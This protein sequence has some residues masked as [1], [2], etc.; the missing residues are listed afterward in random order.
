MSITVKVTEFIPPN[1]RTKERSVELP[2][3]C[4]VGYEALV[5][6]GCRLTVEHL[7]TGGFSQCIEHPEGDYDNQIFSKAS[8]GQQILVD[9]VKQFGNGSQFDRWLED[10]TGID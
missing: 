9:M 5:R 10:V 4:A 2:N 7:P 6:K 3:D 8:Q 1:G